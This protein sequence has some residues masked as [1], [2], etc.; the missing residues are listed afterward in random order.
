MEESLLRVPSIFFFLQQARDF[1]FDDL[2]RRFSHLSRCV[3][4]FAADS[5]T[6][7]SR[8]NFGL[9]KRARE[10]TFLHILVEGNLMFL[11][12]VCRV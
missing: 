5:G 2:D 11:S 4:L 6:P 10:L 7:F 3:Q 8:Q 12:V 9:K 1:N